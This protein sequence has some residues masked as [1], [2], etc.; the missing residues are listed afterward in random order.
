[1]AYVLSKQIGVVIPV[2]NRPRQILE[3]LEG[4]TAQTRRPDLVVVVDDGSDE[5]VE[6][7]IE[8]WQSEQQLPLDLSVHTQTNQGAPSARNRGFAEVSSADFVAFLDSDDLWPADFLERAADRLRADPTAVGAVAGRVYEEG[9]PGKLLRSQTSKGIE[10]DA[11]TWLLRH[12]GGIGSASLLRA[13]A[14]VSAGGYDETLATGHDS[15]LFLRLSLLGP[16]L[17]VPG[18]FVRYRSGRYRE[19]GEESHLRYRYRDFR[20]RWAEIDEEFIEREGGSAVVPRAFYTRHLARRWRKAGEQLLE[21][22][23]IDQ[24]RDCFRR[25][26]AWRLK[27]RTLKGLASSY[28]PGSR[29]HLHRS[30][31][32]PR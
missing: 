31:A 4:V 12:G 18:E 7:L 26:L 13:K 24:A 23:V 22:G 8:Q 14:L 29:P 9:S 21:Q 20:A 30:E 25:S 3:A 28:S 16:W 19:D 1:V 15:A 5:P 2:Y 32:G 11:T 10:R 17:H 27:W 6:Y